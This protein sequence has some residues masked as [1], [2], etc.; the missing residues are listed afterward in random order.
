MAT[1]KE[2]QELLETIKRPIKHYRITISGYGGEMVYN[3]ITK[4]QFEYWSDKKLSEDDYEWDALESYMFDTE[5]F[6]DNTTLPK[7]VDFLK[8]DEH[9][10]EWYEM[11]DIEHTNGVSYDSACITVDE[12]E[13]DEYNSNHIRDV[14]PFSNVNEL[15]QADTFTREDF[16]LDSFADK[17]GNNYVLY[18][19]SVEKGTFFDGLL[20]IEGA[21][22]DPNRLHISTM[23][24]PNGDE[25]ITSVQYN[26]EEVYNDGGDTTGKSLNAR[27]WNY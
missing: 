13:S 4:E 24:Y 11:S 12:V 27:V 3:K 7:H 23:E 22:F 1:I 9:R 25:L 14:M 6:C 8:Q 18:A 5:N 17:D 16:D 15:P 26:G 10:T 2:K 20:T 21:S 19:M